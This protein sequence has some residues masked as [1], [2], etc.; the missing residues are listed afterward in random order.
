VISIR[1]LYLRG[2][3]PTTVAMLMR[4]SRYSSKIMVKRKGRRWHRN[5]ATYIVQPSESGGNLLTKTLTE[6]QNGQHF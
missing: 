4:V 6:I 5:D 1:R 2:L 3:T